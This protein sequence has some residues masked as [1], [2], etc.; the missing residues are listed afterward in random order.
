MSDNWYHGVLDVLGTMTLYEPLDE[1]LQTIIY[2]TDGTIFPPGRKVQMSLAYYRIVFDHHNA[3]ARLLELNLYASAFALARPQYESLVKG[4]WLGYFATESVAEEIA[5]GEELDKIDPLTKQLLGADLPPVVGVHIRNIKQ[6]Y[7]KTLSSLTHA[8]HQQIRRWLNPN[9]V[10]PNYQD[11]E[12]KDLANF[13]SFMCLVAGI[14]KARLGS[15][16]RAVENLSRMLPLD[17]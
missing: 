4:L 13:S 15:N 17:A 7:W 5:R 9:G 12:V 8:G 16:V 6:R 1:L 14:E 10:A 3:I 2:E 11:A